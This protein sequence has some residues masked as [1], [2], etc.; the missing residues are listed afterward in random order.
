MPTASN[1]EP[2]RVITEFS[3]TPAD[4]RRRLDLGRAQLAVQCGTVRQ[5]ADPAEHPPGA[6]HGRA[7]GRVEQKELLLDPHGHAGGSG[8]VAGPWITE[9]S[10]PNREP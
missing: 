9:P 1:R 5:P 10:V 4:S 6:W 3:G 7:G 2:R 8:F